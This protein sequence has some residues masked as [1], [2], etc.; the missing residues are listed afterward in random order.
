MALSF[1]LISPAYAQSAAGA[2]GFDFM[3]LLPLMI[4]FVAFYFLLIRPQQ[5]KAQQQREMLTSVTR[6]DKIVTV[7]GVIG[8]I[9]SVEDDVEVVLELEEGV[10]MRILK[11]AIVEVISSSGS[12][13]KKMS[14]GGAASTKTKPAR[15]TNPKKAP[16]DKTIN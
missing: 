6:G 16:K 7:G 12:N 14:E 11:S 9:V 4:I 13:V 5:K 8:K 2:G 15:P 10:R 1:D 3:G